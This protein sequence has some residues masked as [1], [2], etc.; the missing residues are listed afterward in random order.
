MT[1]TRNYNSEQSTGTFRGC[2]TEKHVTS[3]GEWDRPAQLHLAETI[4]K[5]LPLDNW[6]GKRN[7][8][9]FGDTVGVSFFCP[10]T[11]AET[12]FGCEV[13][14]GVFNGIVLP[15][16]MQETPD[17]IIYHA[18]HE[19]SEAGE[20][21]REEEKQQKEKKKPPRAAEGAREEVEE[22]SHDDLKKELGLD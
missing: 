6:N 19:A 11:G 13:T 22:I 20:R 14:R 9:M 21:Y 8:L 4:I 7:Y 15:V 10:V 3:H 1:T 18:P 16:F 17:E 2:T 12:T 5:A